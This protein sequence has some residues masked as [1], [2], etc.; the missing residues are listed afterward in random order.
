MRNIEKIEKTLDAFK[1]FRS[2]L[3]SISK[4]QG[5]D[6]KI[7]DWISKEISSADFVIA[8]LDKELS[9]AKRP[10]DTNEF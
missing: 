8:N 1:L 10:K 4:L 7:D 2:T 6:E 3:D 9:E 5:K